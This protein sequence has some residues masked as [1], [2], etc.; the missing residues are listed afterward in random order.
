MLPLTNTIT[1]G[2][3]SVGKRSAGRKYLETSSSK[4]GG[5]KGVASKYRKRIND[6]G[7]NQ[8]LY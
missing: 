4:V 8:H 2:G 1:K 5:S 7:L 3:H 6:I